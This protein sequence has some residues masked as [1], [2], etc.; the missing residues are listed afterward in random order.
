VWERD[1]RTAATHGDRGPR[2]SSCSLTVVAVT[3]SAPIWRRVQPWAYPA[4]RVI[5]ATTGEPGL[6]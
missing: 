5:T 6:K 2:R 4:G 3:Q 1:E